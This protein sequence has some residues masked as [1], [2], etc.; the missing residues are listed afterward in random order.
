MNIIDFPEGK[1]LLGP[2]V[3]LQWNNGRVQKL[4]A[5]FLRSRCPCELCRTSSIKLEPSMFPGLS[6]GSL[7]F[8][9]AYALQLHFSDGHKHGAFTFD[10]LEKLPDNA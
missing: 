6:V 9:G 10:L 8:V 4:G 7:D 5:D 3:E 2:V 1:L